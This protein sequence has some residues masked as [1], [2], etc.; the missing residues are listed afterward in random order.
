MRENLQSDTHA[1]HPRF[2]IFLS[3]SNA[4][5]VYKMCVLDSLKHELPSDLPQVQCSLSIFSAARSLVL[6]C[7]MRIY[8]SHH[9]TVSSI[10]HLNAARLR[11][12]FTIAV[13]LLPQ[14]STVT[15]VPTP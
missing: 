13:L 8:A 6:Q 1:L 5:L 15:T 11:A 12:C 14:R 2:F 4:F 3:I 10:Q 7:A 9:S